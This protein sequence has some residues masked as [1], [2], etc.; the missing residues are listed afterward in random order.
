WKNRDLSSYLSSLLIHQGHVYGMNDGGEFG[1]VRL[2]DG[3]TVWIDGR[4]GFYCT[5]LLAGSELLCLN[6]KGDL[7][8]LAATP[9]LFQPLGEAKLANRATWTSPALAGKWLYI[10]ADERLMAFKM[11]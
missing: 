8:L 6:E 5:P 3:K 4:H 1:C 7:L 10:R 9:K 11:R 2:S